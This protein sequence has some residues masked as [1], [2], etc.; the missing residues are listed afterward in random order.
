LA[1][2]LLN[3]GRQQE[4]MKQL[5]INATLMM[6]VLLPATVGMCLLGPALSPLLVAKPYQ[7][8]TAQV[9][10][11]SVLSGM[12]RNLHVH[13]TD[14]LMLLQRRMKMMA[15]VSVIEIVAC[16]AATL[17]GLSLAPGRGGVMGQAVGSAVALAV[18]MWWVHRH[19]S[20]NWPW[21]DTARI[22]LA[23]ACMCGAMYWLEPRQTGLAA[24]V[25]WGMAG[26]VVYALSGAALFHHLIRDW[27]LS[28]RVD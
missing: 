22:L 8:V 24:L 4:A 2:R 21:R 27:Y 23:C 19:L 20:F 25:I 5:Q 7:A 16:T 26:A 13:A 6:A 17:I 18:S 28:R 1:A 9:I 10:G 11:L 12:L 3:E 14:Q 15:G